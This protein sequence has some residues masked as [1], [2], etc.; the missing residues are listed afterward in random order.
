MFYS[1]LSLFISSTATEF[2]SSAH[3]RIFK[4][5]DMGV[6]VEMICNL[7]SAIAELSYLRTRK[8]GMK[9]DFLLLVTVSL[10]ALW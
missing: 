2:I 7:Y 8:E 3:M 6:H 4:E 9:L 5:Y 10:A 1:G